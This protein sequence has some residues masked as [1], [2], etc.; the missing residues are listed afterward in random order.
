MVACL[1]TMTKAPLKM[2]QK[3]SVSSPVSSGP[4][5]RIDKSQIRRCQTQ[6][7][8]QYVAPHPV[9]FEATRLEDG[10]FRKWQFLSLIYLE[11]KVKRKLLWQSLNYIT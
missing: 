10:V 11:Y 4:T 9:S 7:I 1:Y 2:E 3:V 6:V 8:K 5:L